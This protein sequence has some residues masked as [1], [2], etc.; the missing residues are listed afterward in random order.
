MEATASHNA[1]RA[2]GVVAAFA[3]GLVGSWTVL[4]AAPGSEMSVAQQNAL[5]RKYCAV[6]HSDATRN[7]GLTLEHFDAMHVDPSLAA[8][9][10]S[11][12]KNGA[13]SAAGVPAPDRA[14]TGA[15]IEVLS[16][17]AAGAHEWT[18][19]RT[20]DI[21]SASMVRDLPSRNNSK[22]PSLYRLVITCN[23]TTGQ[24]AM[25][26]SWSP[27]PRAGTLTAVLDG[28]ETRTYQVEGKE[29]MGNGSGGTTGPAAITLYDRPKMPAQTL[30]MS[31]LFPGE[32][33]T[34]PFET[35]PQKVHRTLSQCFAGDGSEQ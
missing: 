15:L 5:V 21:V 1:C 32:T 4:L 26:L 10:V 30:A 33:V 20:D 11:K 25:Q 27:E 28:R 13:I 14:T 12:L 6:C 8:M 29:T 35:L 16:S 31:G 7:G 3:A 19:R 23:A 9:L 18:V 22:E 34:F 24:G 17:E 2:I